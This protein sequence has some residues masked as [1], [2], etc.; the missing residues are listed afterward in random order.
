M[1]KLTSCN[2]TDFSITMKNLTSFHSTFFSR[3]S[4]IVISLVL[5]R[6]ATWSFQKTDFDVGKL[7]FWKSD[8]VA[9]RPSPLGGP[10]HAGALLVGDRCKDGDCG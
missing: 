8:H 7:Y 1:K 6:W 2:T 3:Y 5:L 4:A 9:Q 10:S